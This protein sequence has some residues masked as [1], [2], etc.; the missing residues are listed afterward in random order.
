[1]TDEQRTDVSDEV[2]PTAIIR[3]AGAAWRMFRTHPS[4]LWLLTVLCLLVTILFFYLAVRSQGT[5][6]TVH[7]AQGHGIKPGDLLRH[8]GIEVGEV[9]AVNL[10]DDL[11]GVAISLELDRAASRL[12]REGSRFWIERPRLSLARVSGLETLVGAKYLGVLPGPPDTPPR[13]TFDGA[14]SPLTLLDPNVVEIEV[15]FRRGHG[16]AV[17]SPLKHRGIDVG[18]VTAVELRDDLAAVTVR[19]RLVETAQRLARAGSQ[20]W[21][22][23]PDVSLT[24][25]RSLETLVGGHYLAVEP[26]PLDAPSLALF[27][28]LE[29]PPSILEQSEGGLEI[30]LASA[31]R[32]GVEAGAPISFRGLS[33][34]HVISVALSPD[35]TKVEARAY[36]RPGYKQLVRDNSKFW[37]TS[38]ID[39]N[40][41]LSGVKLNA[42]TLKTI[43]AGG[44]AFATPNAPGERVRAGHA[45][46]L[47]KKADDDWLEYD[48]RLPVGAPLL[49]DDAVLPH[50]L[51]VTLRWRQT[52]LRIPRNRDRDAWALLLDN[53]ELVAPS[54][55]L[56]ASVKAI[57]DSTRIEFEGGEHPFGRDS[58]SYHGRLAFFP[59]GTSA[60]EPSKIWPLDKI[61]VADKPEDCLIV[62]GPQEPHLYL[63]AARIT[64][65]ESSWQVDPSFTI[66]PESQ[67]ASVVA[68]ADGC[69]LGLIVFKK[70]QARI[71]LMT[72]R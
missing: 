31:R 42:D 44:V 8:R 19:V 65:V 3:P 6:I 58:V 28:G 62:P 20:F 18:E 45:F 49:P 43:A 41:G 69:L 21:V 37:S 60:A 68:A 59:V 26:G 9:V 15:R 40:I 64:Q 23:R 12:A 16:L 63:Q 53:G 30:V 72:D 35:A 71:A 13:F 57:P 47:A 27:D 25:V 70:G 34:G 36:I 61:R 10:S 32:L 39:L 7:F 56:S 67:G 51:R 5:R 52:T 29:D 1:M 38:G 50:P 55:L 17:G 33:V 24:G 22:E 46:T 48:P 66:K 2:M 11:G 54:E 4:R 14:E